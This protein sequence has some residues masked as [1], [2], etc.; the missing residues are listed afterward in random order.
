MHGIHPIF[1]R[2]LFCGGTDGE[3]GKVKGKEQK[4][5]HGEGYEQ[6]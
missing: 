5:W 2:K 1:T 3:E 6:T 4:S